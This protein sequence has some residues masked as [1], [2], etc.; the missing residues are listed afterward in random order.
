MSTTRY[1]VNVH[2]DEGTEV[3]ASRLPGFAAVKIGD[4]LSL[5]IDHRSVDVA[6]TLAAAIHAACGDVERNPD[7]PVNQFRDIYVPVAV[8]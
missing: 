5:F 4:N 2:L 8:A 6:R 3:E 1:T 7:P